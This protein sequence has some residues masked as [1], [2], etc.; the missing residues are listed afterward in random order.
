M[1]AEKKNA[2]G[3]PE[4]RTGPVGDEEEG[5]DGEDVVRSDTVVR[6]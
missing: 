3:R 6:V 2:S 4:N 5:A 1:C